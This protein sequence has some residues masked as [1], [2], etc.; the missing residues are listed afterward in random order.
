MRVALTLLALIKGVSSEQV[1]KGS[2]YGL[3]VGLALVDGIRAVAPDVKLEDMKVLGWDLTQDG[4]IVT[5]S[6]HITGQGQWEIPL[7]EDQA[8]QSGRFANRGIVAA[9]FDLEDFK[10]AVAIRYCK[11]GSAHVSIDRGKLFEKWGE[12]NYKYVK[13]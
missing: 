10:D 2:T 8:R 9:E 4:G 6:E 5:T 12:S 1:F 7:T 13:E 3:P 11:D